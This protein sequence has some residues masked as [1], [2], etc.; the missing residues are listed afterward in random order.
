VVNDAALVD[1]VMPQVAGYVRSNIPTTDQ[2]AMTT[3]DR[4]LK[5][6]NT[7]SPAA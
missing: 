5:Q 6:I 3:P 1:P 7:L 4:S 2:E